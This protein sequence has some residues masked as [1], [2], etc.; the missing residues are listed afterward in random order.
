MIAYLTVVVVTLHLGLISYMEPV[1]FSSFISVPG[2]LQ[3]PQQSTVQNGSYKHK[4]QYK[5]QDTT[6]LYW[7]EIAISNSQREYE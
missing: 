2:L 4:Q 6:L 3:L 1:R 7:R 5:V